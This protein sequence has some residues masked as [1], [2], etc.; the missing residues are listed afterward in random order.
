MSFQPIRATVNV[1]IEGI[2]YTKDQL[3]ELQLRLI[4]AFKLAWFQLNITCTTHSTIEYS[5]Q[6]EI[7]K[8]N[9]ERRRKENE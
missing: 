6:N 4:E 3:T 8:R 1:Q 5:M 7:D 2:S 9:D